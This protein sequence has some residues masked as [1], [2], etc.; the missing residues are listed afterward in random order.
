MLADPPNRARW[1]FPCAFIVACVLFWWLPDLLLAWLRLPDPVHARTIAFSLVALAVFL[2][3]YLVPQSASKRGFLSPATLDACEALAWKATLILSV[4]AL[5][6]GISFA[7]YRARVAYG[8]G[9]D[10]PFLF[11]AVL[12]SHLFF[13]Y[14]FLGSVPGLAGAD[15]RRVFVA[16]ALLILPRLLISL[17]WARFF[18]GQTIVILLLV[19]MARGWLRL[20]VARWLQL[21]ALAAAIVFVPAL[22][23]GD[24]IAGDST[25]GM[26]R[27]VLFFQ[28]GSTLGF[29]QQ[30]RNL[31]PQCPPLLVSMT[32]QV[33]PWSWLHT[34]TITV[35][36]VRDTPAV[37][38]SI[39][40][41]QDSNDF[42]LGTGSNYL[43]ELYL[44]GGI[45]AVLIGSALFGAACRW[46]VEHL[47]R[48]SL[49][50][51]IWAECLVRA[52]LAPRG[53]L[54][55]VCERIPSLLLATAAVVLL[56]RAAAVLRRPIA[57][58]AAPQDA[59]G[60]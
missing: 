7:L 28:S 23:R 56:C 53:N 9:A 41:R 51:G 8:Q 48:R 52:L 46:F 54:G 35:G 38:S 26:P 44:T 34:C 49:L 25:D 15:R 57:L 40:T 50:A 11:Q 13:G 43:L 1:L 22:T 36:N 3:G 33:I 32:A 39:L 14:M 29:L 42:A 24:R 17:H 31:H 37:L 6:V 10:I 12:Y 60:I 59:A 2:A 20:S 27:M 16:S 5:L 58:R 4:P 45:A 21:G 30:Y 18:V 47:G 19:A 55:Y